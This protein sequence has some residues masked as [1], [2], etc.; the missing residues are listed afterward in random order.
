MTAEKILLTIRTV[1]MVD[2]DPPE[3]MELQSEGTLTRFPDRVELSYVE[4][5]M[6]GLEGVATTFTVFTDGSVRLTRDGKALQSCMNFRLNQPDDSLYDVG[7]GA[8]LLTVTA[9][10]IQ[11]DWVR[12]RLEVEYDVQVEHSRMGTNLYHIEYRKL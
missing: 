7:F 11:V 6:T 5:E 4:S 9:R 12:H 2:G 1:Q 10:R 8:L 3:V